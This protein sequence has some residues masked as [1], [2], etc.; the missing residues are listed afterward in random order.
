MFYIS[1]GLGILWFLIW[2]LVVS[3][4]PSTQRFISETEKNYILKHR[5]QIDEI[6]KSRPP[7]LKIL[8]TPSVWALMICDFARSFGAYMVI[9]EGPNF[10]D[11][12]LNKDILEVNYPILYIYIS[13]NKHGKNHSTL[14]VH[15]IFHF[16]ERH[17]KR[18]TSNDMF[19]VWANI[20]LPIGSSD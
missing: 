11:K 18:I 17:F 5:K 20:L 8:L 7:Y 2:I 14:R 4:D 19:L 6:G 3:D 1:G 9:I 16:L 10:I 15:F 12:V 13:I